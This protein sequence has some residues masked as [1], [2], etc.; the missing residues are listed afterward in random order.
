MSLCIFQAGVSP[1]GLTRMQEQ[2]STYT[3]RHVRC[4]ISPHHPSPESLQRSATEGCYICLLFIKAL[5]SHY[6][7]I[8]LNSLECDESFTAY[9]YA[10]HVEPASQHQH[11][12]NFGTVIRYQRS[13][14]SYTSWYSAYMLSRSCLAIS[15][16]AFPVPCERRKQTLHQQ[17]RILGT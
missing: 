4:P 11:H 9:S 2:R 10:G 16:M 12:Q 15:V 6:R 3:T 13:L 8:E 17:L 1:L 7:G 14:Q 5:M